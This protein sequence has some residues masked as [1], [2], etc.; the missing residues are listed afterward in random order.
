MYLN[1]FHLV[2]RFQGTD[3]QC[4]MRTY[5][6]FSFKLLV[7][8]KTE[9]KIKETL[10]NIF[11]YNFHSSILYIYNSCFILLVSPFDG[12]S[13]KHDISEL[14]SARSLHK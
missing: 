2:L 7:T 14:F 5:S 9:Y 4:K 6:T 10:C 11:T 12:A 13:F 3:S 8:Y 1:D